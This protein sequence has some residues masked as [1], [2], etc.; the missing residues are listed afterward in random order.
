[1]RM[2]KVNPKKILPKNGLFKM[3][4]YFVRS[5]KSNKNHRKSNKSKSSLVGGFNPIEKY[6]RQNGFIFPK[7]RGENKKYCK[8]PP[9]SLLFVKFQR[10]EGT[11][12]VSFCAKF[13]IQTFRRNALCS[14]MIIQPLVRSLLWNLLKPPLVGISYYTKNSLTY[15]R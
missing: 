3:V 9:R 7:V 15:K 5:N 14:G 10:G 13:F 12:M 11:F 6:A 2:E 8:P 1:M 4:I